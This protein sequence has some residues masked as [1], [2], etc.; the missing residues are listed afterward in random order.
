MTTGRNEGVSGA[1]AH[2]ASEAAS[3]EAAGM[4]A[5]ASETA[6]GALDGNDG[7]RVEKGLGLGSDRG[8]GGRGGL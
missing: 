8:A 6:M 7:V 4:A 5:R 3:S 1:C 2:V